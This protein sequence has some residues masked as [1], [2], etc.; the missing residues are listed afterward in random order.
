MADDEAAYRRPP[1]HV[2][3]RRH[4]P[5]PRL[6]RDVAVAQLATSSAPAPPPPPS[7]SPRSPTAVRPPSS[8]RTACARCRPT[9]GSARRCTRPPRDATARD[10]AAAPSPTMTRPAG[11]MLYSSMPSKYTPSL[12]P[13]AATR[14]NTVRPD[15][16]RQPRQRVRHDRQPAL[17]VD[18]RQR[19]LHAPEARDRLIDEQRQQVAVQRR[20]LHAA[21]HLEPQD[22]AAHAARA[23][24]SAARSVS[25]SVTAITS[26][27]PIRS[28]C[29]QQ[30][31]HGRH[32]VAVPRVDV[33]VSS[34][35]T[36][37]CRR[38]R[39]ARCGH[40]RPIQQALASSTLGPLLLLTANA[41]P[42]GRLGC[43]VRIFA[44]ASSLLSLDFY[45]V[46]SS[47]QALVSRARAA[48]GA[49]RPRDWRTIPA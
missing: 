14:S 10:S 3:R 40:L 24:P 17:P 13:T 34:A 37:H 2:A 46:A 7:S 21:D 38:S 29:V 41:C 47:P 45:F 36:R 16:A 25:C 49:R 43:E 9:A 33:E 15:A 6:Q 30:L 11:L 4:H 5:A 48:A 31:R 28:T 35:H 18:R 26:S 27:V 8:P 32:P 19:L 12:P 20:H 39:H 22:A 1:P 42:R 44:A 23:P